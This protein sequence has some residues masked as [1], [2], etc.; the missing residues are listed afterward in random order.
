MEENCKEAQKANATIVFA[1]ESGIQMSPNMKRTW[2]PRGK[3]PIIRHAT[4]SY[5]KVSAMG[6]IAV[7]PKGRRVR[8]FFRLLE[9]ANF[10]TDYCIA[11]IEQLKQNIRGKIVLIWDRFLPHRCKKMQKYLGKQHRVKVHYFPPYAPELNP[12]EYMWAH[13]KQ[14]HLANRSCFDL[15]ELYRK[16]KTSMCAIRGDSDLMKAFIKHSPLATEMYHYL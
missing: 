16:S 1:D 14:N 10:N 4:R 12:V 7:T 6:A 9:N 13:L 2:A 3:T 15:D 5:R 8:S 11:F